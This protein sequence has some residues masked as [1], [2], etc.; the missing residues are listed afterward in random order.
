M[1]RRRG[2]R[3]GRGRGQG[4][5]LVEK[6]RDLKEL[7]LRDLRPLE[8][9]PGTPDEIDL[10]TGVLGGDRNVV[11][12]ASRRD[13]LDLLGWARVALMLADR[14][15]ADDTLV[16]APTF[17]SATRRAAEAA[18]QNGLRLGLIAVPALAEDGQASAPEWYPEP[19]YAG[20]QGLV[21]DRVIRVVEG[22][23]AVS[24]VG[25]LRR[26]GAGY[27]LYAR[28]V[29]VLRVASEGDGVAVSFM[30]PEKRHVHVTEDNFSRWG[31]ELHE[32][33]LKLAQDPRLLGRPEEQTER[34][35][36]QAATA[37]GVRITARWIPWNDEGSA[38]LD[39]A[40]I[41]SRGR[42]VLGVVRPSVGLA[43]VP[44]IAAGLERLRAE[45]ELWTPGAQG[46]PHL[47]L[48]TEQL[49]GRARVLLESLGASVESRALESPV[50]E[51]PA[52][53]GGERRGRRRTRRRR[54]RRGEEHL[55]ARDERAEE[56]DEGRGASREEAPAE[57]SSEVSEVA[58]IEED[59]VA[60]ESEDV[61][62]PLAAQAEALDVEQEPGAAD[63]DELAEAEALA[64]DTAAPEVEA[65]PEPLAVQGL[66]EEE[67]TE[68][69]QPPERERPR[70]RRARAAIC[71]RN[72]PDAILA[73]LILA[74]DR[75][76]IPFFWVCAQE[77]LM[78]FFRGKATDVD[79]NTDLLLVGFTAEPIPRETIRSAELF[80]DRIQWFDAHEW[81][82]ED[83]EAL[84]GAIG[85]D[86]VVVNERAS[87]PL[88]AVME[89]TER[90]SRFT[91]K[92]VDFSARR[93]GENDMQKWGYRLGGLLKKA[94]STTADYRQA[95][96]PV[97]S[98][99]PAELPAADTVYEEEE[100]WLEEHDPRIVHFGEYQLAVV[101]VPAN[102][103]AGEVGRRAR[104]RTGARLSL[105]SREGDP[106][107]ILGANDEKRSIN[108][109]GV[110][111][112]VEASVEWAHARPAGDRAARLRV[113][114]LVEHPERLD[115]VIGEIARHKSVLYG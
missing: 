106:L 54:G 107:V 88:T 13:G 73:A 68:Q 45:P 30:A 115:A 36:E 59:E 33:V 49:D 79:E 84:R 57:P 41:G 37:S 104:V 19:R 67:P 66:D 47:V 48:A 34:A 62:E 94:A 43:D 70:S 27:V 97:L 51:A 61:A 35:A 22:A 64:D 21:L 32:S 96:S 52:E 99:K 113:D 111:E 18:A 46:P 86:A 16:A 3:G 100:R 90:R 93:I 23:S 12:V 5:R 98:G 105:V 11:V 9:L 108:L 92:L 31:L 71:V 77:E 40:G 58:P 8:R 56:R 114:A 39:W 29:R 7:G 74:R 102:L 42:P 101:Q 26:A 17:S 112:R 80:R 4:G 69:E 15:R 78:D 24:S 1:F 81:P 50:E 38:P 109:M 83:V 87:S 95:I 82:I 28:G 75:R 20:S 63:A 25:V 6:L 10:A 76:H 110:A 2:L 53:A 44:A 85:E 60:R 14:S 103:D 65:E 91:D 72:D 89:M 55:A